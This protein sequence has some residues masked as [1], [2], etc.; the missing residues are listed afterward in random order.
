MNAKLAKRLRKQSLQMS[1]GLK[2]EFD[3]EGVPTTIV[4]TTRLVEKHGF[5]PKGEPVTVRVPTRQLAWHRQKS[6]RG[7]YKSLKD[8][9]A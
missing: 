6:Q 5:T 1:A 8:Q 7:I 3:S 4:L 9:H 2:P